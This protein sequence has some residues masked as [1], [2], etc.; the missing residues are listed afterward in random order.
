MIFRNSLRAK[1]FKD[2]F[3]T[4]DKL[5]K[6]DV[7]SVHVREDIKNCLKHIIDQ[8]LQRAFRIRASKPGWS[9][10]SHYRSLSLAQRIWLDDAY[11]DER[12]NQN[13][14]IDD[15]S[16]SLGRWIIQTYEYSFRKS[17]VKL[18][19]EELKTHS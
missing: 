11:L 10:T 5:I 4:L 8:V 2:T 3:Q 12:K 17:H 15:I 18:S 19:H 1:S 6:A 9:S 7:N 16:N 14:W 13:E